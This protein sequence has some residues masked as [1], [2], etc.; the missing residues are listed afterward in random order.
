MRGRRATFDLFLRQA[1]DGIDGIFR[2]NEANA[3]SSF[4][5]NSLGVPASLPWMTLLFIKTDEVFPGP[6]LR[7]EGSEGKKGGGV[8]NGQVTP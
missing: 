3:L 5:V 2:R 8:G 7:F 6:P 1:G 4:K